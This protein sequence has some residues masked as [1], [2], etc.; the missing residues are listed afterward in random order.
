MEKLF[1]GIDIQKRLE[2]KNFYLKRAFS[3]VIN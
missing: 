3:F 2:Y 1:V